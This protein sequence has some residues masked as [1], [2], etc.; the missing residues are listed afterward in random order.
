MELKDLAIKH[1]Y[2]A[3]D[4][5]YYSRDAAQHYNTWA[6]F[7]EEFFDAD[8]DMNLVYRWDITERDKSGRYY[9][10][11]FVICQR[12]GIYMPIMI[13]YVDEK[14]VPQIIEFM[15]PHFEKLLSIWNPLSE[16]F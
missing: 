10:E 15:K 13:D 2:Y 6:D 16:K 3:S 1:P 12:K 4:S 7:Y 8:I 14:D 9:M 5:N 11:V